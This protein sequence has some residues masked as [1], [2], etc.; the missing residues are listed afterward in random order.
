MSLYNSINPDPVRAVNV[1]AAPEISKDKKFRVAVC[2]SGQA[3]HWRTAVSNNL[4][5]FDWKTH[6]VLDIPVEVD[7]FIHTWDTNTWRYPKQGHDSFYLEKHNDTEDLQAAYSP[8]GFICEEFTQDKFTRAWDPMFYSH[9]RSLMMKRDYELK[10]LFQYD[11]VIKA[12]LDVVYD[13]M[14]KFPLF[15]IWPMVCYTCTPISKFPQEFNYNNFDDVLFYGDSPTMDLVGDI[16]DRN[17]QRH[18]PYLVD[19]TNA[20]KN[21]DVTM[22]YGPG[23]SLYDHCTDLGI[24]PEGV[25]V[26][27]YAVVRSTAVAE[28]LD[29][30]ND[31]QKI[32]QKWFDWYI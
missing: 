1:Q 26:I 18:T 2:Y 9:A 29:G 7:Y 6:P 30:L 12:R 14:H 15:H 19:K 27:E 4:Q 16:Y 22:W 11:L 28:K 24:H 31:Y 8:K 25:R 5:F 20:G 13:T 17:R 21:L 3:R 23:C 32:R 10:N